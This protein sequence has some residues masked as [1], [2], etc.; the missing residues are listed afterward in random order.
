MWSVSRQAALR[1]SM[2]RSSNSFM[3]VT[4]AFNFAKFSRDKPHL[5]VGTVGH[6]D[7]GKT[8]LTAAITKY[9]AAK[10]AATNFKD[11]NDIDKSPEEKARGITINA[12]TVEYETETRH[13][14]HVDCP[15]HADYVKNMITGA[16]RMD[17]GILVV[18]AVDGAMPQTREHILLCRQVGVKSLIVF[19]NKIDLVEDPEMH[20]LVE[21]EVRELLSYYDFDGDNIPFVKGSALSALNDTD[22]EIGNQAIEK[23]VQAMDANITEPTREAKK[24]FL[25]SIDSSLNIPGRGC[26]VTGTIEQG[27]IKINDDVHMIG[28]RRK[29][30]ATTIT[31]IETFHKQ[32]DSGEAGDNIGVLLRGVTK[33]QIRRGMCLAKPNSLEIR[34]SFEGEIYVLKPDE[35]GRSKPFFSGYRPQC[36][37]RTA[38]VAVDLTLPSDLQ[39]AMPGDNVTTTMKLNFP[40]PIVKGQ[41][42]ALR[43]GGKTVAAGVIT[44]L[45]EDT[46]A[47]IKEEEERLAKAKAMK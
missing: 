32:L 6:V 40:L 1:S 7:H 35:G 14:G 23:L 47:D 17:G 46:E 22:D 38:D 8:T 44:K 2:L 25:M 37:I 9:L 39:M 24:D 12:T 41:R 20:E 19:L 21:M 4:P 31:G 28:I 18:S 3:G 27:K 34:R 5:N 16:A 29:H 13:Y 33:D 45:L 43:E 42:F 30:T 11:Y 36:F 26:V 15:G 10:N